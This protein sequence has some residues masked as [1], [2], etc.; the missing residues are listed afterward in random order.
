MHCGTAEPGSELESLRTENAA[1]AQ[2]L[3]IATALSAKR[4]LPQLLQAS[5]EAA[6]ALSGASSADLQLCDEGTDTMRL[7]AQT[8]LGLACLDQFEWARQ[9]AGSVCWEVR[10]RGV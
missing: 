1:L 5:I 7:V 4:S 3:E 2:L 6:V 9:A 10:R 8:G